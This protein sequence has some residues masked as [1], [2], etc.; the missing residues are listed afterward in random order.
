MR[1]AREAREFSTRPRKLLSL[2]SQSKSTRSEKSWL[3]V[4]TSRDVNTKETRSSSLL[5]C[6]RIRISG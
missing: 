6:M 2:L 1:R 5:K 4:M 3:L